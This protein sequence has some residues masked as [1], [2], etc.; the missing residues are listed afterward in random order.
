MQF[1]T[2][3]DAAAFVFITG[4][5]LLFSPSAFGGNTYWI[6]TINSCGVAL[7]IEKALKRSAM[8]LVGWA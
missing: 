6:F 1:A 5:V 3:M 2:I 7:G 8:I 4:S